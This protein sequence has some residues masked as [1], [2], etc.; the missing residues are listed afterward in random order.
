[1]K[2]AVSSTP[3]WSSGRCTPPG[4]SPK[5]VLASFI[6]IWV[7]SLPTRM[8]SLDSIATLCSQCAPTMQPLAP[9]WAAT[10]WSMSMLAMAPSFL[11][12]LPTSFKFR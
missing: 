9:K 3:S 8:Y 1:M 11:L 6:L 4:M 2:E 7:P 5:R 10:C 12:V